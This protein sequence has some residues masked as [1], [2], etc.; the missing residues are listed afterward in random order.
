[1][2]PPVSPPERLRQ[3]YQ[4]RESELESRLAIALQASDEEGRIQAEKM[5]NEELDHLC[6]Q[7]RLS[8]GEYVMWYVALVSMSVHFTS[9]CFVFSSLFL[10]SISRNFSTNHRS[11]DS[12]S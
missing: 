3:D 5:H 4:E 6:Q 8:M 2:A 7:H 9:N 12:Y 10:L 1:M 11:R